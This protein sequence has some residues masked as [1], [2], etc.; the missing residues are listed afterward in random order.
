MTRRIK[1]TV[2]SPTRVKFRGEDT[3]RMVATA[4]DGDGVPNEIFVH[5]RT[6]VNPLT[7]RECDE[8]IS[9]ASAYDLSIYPANEPD[10]SQSPAFFR[11]STIDILVPSV[12]V[13]DQAK[14][15]LE[16]QVCHLVRV[17][18]RL[19]VLS[20]TD[21]AWCPSPPIEEPEESSESL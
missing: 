12:S 13:F 4:S 7:R 8:F 14:I 16:T 11:K 5:Q 17:L 10:D 15:D 19:D 9:V 21:T 1:L 2:Q 3:F 20:E 6:L 18:N